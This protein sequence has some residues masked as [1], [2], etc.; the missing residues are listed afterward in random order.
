MIRVGVG[1][2][3]GAVVNLQAIAQKLYQVEFRKTCH[4]TK[5][6]LRF[7]C[8][9]VIR[10]QI[11]TKKYLTLSNSDETWFLHSAC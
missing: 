5:N 11:N 2:G 9:W 6:A 4:W 3:I 8:M 7:I 10:C 1:V